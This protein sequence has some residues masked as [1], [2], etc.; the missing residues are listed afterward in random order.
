MIKTL[1]TCFVLFL[2]LSYNIVSAQDP[3]ENA[4]KQY[5]Y[6]E[7]IGDTVVSYTKDDFKV[8]IINNK[9]T[10]NNNR[11]KTFFKGEEVRNFPLED[12]KYEVRDVRIFNNKDFIL[13]FNYIR[14][15]IFYT[16]S[17]ENDHWIG[18]EYGVLGGY[19]LPNGDPK[20]EKIEA[21][22]LNKFI[23]TRADKKYLLQYDQ[24]APRLKRVSESEIKE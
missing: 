2:V 19:Y 14:S 1:M 7:L 12:F 16:Y 3:E 23:V 18:K 11:I 17:W 9:E 21:I 10:L 13:V 6:Q 15:V 22:D 5:T 4:L 24:K 20:P 8:L